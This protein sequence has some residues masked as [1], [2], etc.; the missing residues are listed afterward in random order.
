MKLFV[1]G[2]KVCMYNMTRAVYIINSKYILYSVWYVFMYV[3]AAHIYCTFCPQVKRK[4]CS[5]T[6]CSKHYIYIH[7]FA[8]YFYVIVYALIKISCIEICSIY[9]IKSLVNHM[10]SDCL[11]YN[12]DRIEYK[13]PHCLDPTLGPKTTK[14]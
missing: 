12:R 2:A 3:C 6:G 10:I 4:H 7:I 5:L 14:I 1:G 8:E 13:I 9:R 11:K